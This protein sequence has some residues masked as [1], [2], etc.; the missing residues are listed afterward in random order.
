[1]T[2]LP[3]FDHTLALSQG[4]LDAAGLAECHAVA[5]GLLVRQPS[6]PA[7]SYLELLAALQVVPGA[8]PAIREALADLYAAVAGQLADDE[9]QFALWLP[10]DEQPLEERTAALAQYEIC[11][12]GGGG[13]KVISC[14]TLAGE[15]ERG[16]QLAET[17]S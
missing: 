6:A 15:F 16:T 1:M 7:G 17:T 5:C 13:S 2:Q 9:M 4:N 11:R 14:T 12:R 8:G 3:D 10:D